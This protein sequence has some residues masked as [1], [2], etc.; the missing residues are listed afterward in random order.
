M[1]QEKQL[2][3]ESSAKLLATE[4]EFVVAES[5]LVMAQTVYEKARGQLNRVAGS[6][7]ADYGIS[8][9]ATRTGR[10]GTNPQ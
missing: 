1:Q 3:V 6:L 5:S 4:H 7:L 2:G 8:I 9:T 10:A